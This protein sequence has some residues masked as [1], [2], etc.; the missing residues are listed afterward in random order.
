MAGSPSNHN[1]K[2]CDVEHQFVP[3]KN[4]PGNCLTEC[5]YYYYISYTGL[6]KC[7]TYPMCPDEAKF[8]IKGKNKCLDDCI[9]D[10]V[11]KFKYKGE[12]LEQCPESTFVINNDYICRENI[13]ND[14]CIIDQKDLAISDFSDQAILENLV[15]RYGEE[16]NNQDNYISLYN[17]DNYNLLIFKKSN[18]VT[19][20]NVRV[21]DFD[22][23]EC[24]TRI[25][26]HYNIEDN[27][28]ITV[29]ESLKKDKN[30]RTISIE[31]FHPQTGE[32]LDVLSIC[33]DDNLVV[34]QNM[35]AFID[36]NNKNYDILID[37][38]DNDI[39]I[40]DSNDDF[41]TDLC[42][43]YLS[44]KKRD[45]PIK[46][47][48]TEF[49]PNITL[50]D[51]GC[52]NIGINLTSHVA[53]CEC[54]YSDILNNGALNNDFME[55]TLVDL[56]KMVEAS[57][58][59]VLKC[60]IKAMKNF[61][62]EVGGFI[63]LG[64]FVCCAISVVLFYC[65]ETI[66]MKTYITKIYDRFKLLILGNINNINSSPPKKDNNYENDD[67]KDDEDSKD[68]KDKKNN[69]LAIKESNSKRQLIRKNEKVTKNQKKQNFMIRKMSSIIIR[70]PNIIPNTENDND[71]LSA[72]KQD[73][74]EIEI[75][76][77]F[78]N[79]YLSKSIQ[80]MGFDD[81]YKYDQRTLWEIFYDSIKD[82]V[83]TINTFFVSDPFMPITLKIVIYIF[84]ITLYFVINGLFYN[85]DY[86][87]EVYHS[88]IDE[89]FFSFVP[90]SIKRFLYTL[91]VEGII[92]VLIHFFIVE[93]KR[94]KKLLVRNQ[95]N[96]GELTK[97]VLKLIKI[98][99]R[100]ILTL[101]I[102][103]LI[104]FVFSFLYV[105]SFNYV[106]HYT[107]FEWIKSSI[108]IFIIIE[109]LIIIIC[110][111]IAIIRKLSL[112]YKSDRLFKLSQFIDEI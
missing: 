41:Y 89:N 88:K 30:N 11:Y 24:Y 96:L 42:F 3:E 43:Y 105:V 99:Q 73:N 106:Y 66:E 35:Y 56:K 70:T 40:F 37:L 17:N 20:L 21:S 110:L 100:R 72:T 75:D 91:M 87:S 82:N 51:S 5:R 79:R 39:N 2:T 57:N 54:K 6:Y 1:C 10:D 94:Y 61:T 52:K 44:P 83:K 32:K 12:C 84:N 47:R 15:K 64:L 85:E 108:F 69:K 78:F 18:C 80:E 8:F 98:I 111:L 26:N 86:I 92:Q 97:E 49:Y 62:K 107:Q 13:D 7:T 34:N 95:E 29:L 104:I 38:L 63:I 45:I 16:S 50:C 76:I 23:G 33:T 27:L 58:I 71:K 48:L 4:T 102:I 81:A 77:T 31:I 53:L 112:K 60:L 103:I 109:F 74:S 25:K 14:K 93:E 59:E 28:I 67:S 55:D 46:D 90:R 9:K 68:S 65:R 36:E 19:D 22:F 101:F